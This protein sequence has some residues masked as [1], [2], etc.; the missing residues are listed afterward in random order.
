MRRAFASLDSALGAVV[1]F[2]GRPA[3]REAA[4][5]AVLD[6][7][8]LSGTRQPQ[9]YLTE[10][11][12]LCVLGDDGQRIARVYGRQVRA[13]VQPAGFVPRGATPS[14]PDSTLPYVLRLPK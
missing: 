7:I 6:V 3:R 4:R 1:P 12:D 13:C 14:N 9:V 8:R 2:L 11:S 10:T 5:A